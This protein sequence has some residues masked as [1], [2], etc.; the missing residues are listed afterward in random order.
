ML[1]DDTPIK[2][3]GTNIDWKVPDLTK[4]NITKVYN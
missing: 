4:R 2:S 1:D 3:I